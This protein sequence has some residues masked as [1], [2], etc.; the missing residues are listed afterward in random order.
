MHQR[1]NI[2]HE[3]PKLL[4]E[5]ARKE[6]GTDAA[7]LCYS[8]GTLILQAIGA[9]CAQFCVLKGLDDGGDSFFSIVCIA[10]GGIFIPIFNGFERRA[11]R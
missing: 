2:S 4:K 1:R 5:F 11:Q 9:Y 10:D 8:G 7:V 3:F 6:V